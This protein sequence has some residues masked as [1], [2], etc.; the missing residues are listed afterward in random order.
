MA[1]ALEDVVIATG[2]NGLRLVFSQDQQG[3][4]WVRVEDYYQAYSYPVTQAIM[5]QIAEAADT[6]ATS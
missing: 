1:A 4:F 6:V 5:E 2:V 3:G